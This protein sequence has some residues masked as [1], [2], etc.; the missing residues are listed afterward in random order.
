MTR[1][2]A[3][4]FDRWIDAWIWSDDILSWKPGQAIFE[5]ALATV[6][7]TGVFRARAEA[8]ARRAFFGRIRHHFPETSATLDQETLEHAA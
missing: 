1:L 2:A 8:R 7:R 5:A 6:P 3:F 4:D